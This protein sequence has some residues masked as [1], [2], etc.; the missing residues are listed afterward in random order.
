MPPS[1]G[2]PEKNKKIGRTLLFKLWNYN[3]PLQLGRTLLA[4][5]TTH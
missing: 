4:N 2:G 3:K 1:L 5:T